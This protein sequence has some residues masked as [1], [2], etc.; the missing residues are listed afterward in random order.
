V[1]TGSVD[2]GHYFCYARAGNEWYKFNDKVVSKVSLEVAI[3]VGMGGYSNSFQ[4]GSWT[5]LTDDPK[6]LPFY[7]I[8]EPIRTQAYL[9]VYIKS[10][11]VPNLIQPVQTCCIPNQLL[12]K[13]SSENNF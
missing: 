2:C 11:E 12:A 10:T 4:Q 3:R 5:A 7:E 13:F 8:Q 1:H 6:M 9:L